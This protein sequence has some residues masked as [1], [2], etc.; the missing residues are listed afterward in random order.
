VERDNGL[1]IISESHGKHLLAAGVQALV[2]DLLLGGRLPLLAE[3]SGDR[4][5][6][7]VRVLKSR[8]KIN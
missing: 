1:I 6:Y 2:L 7:D 3:S 4:R 5:C 8:P